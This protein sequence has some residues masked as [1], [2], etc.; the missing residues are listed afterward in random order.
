MLKKRC[1]RLF[2]LTHQYIKPCGRKSAIFG[3]SG[4]QRGP[5]STPTYTDMA[6][7]EEPL[8]R[9]KVP[10]TAELR[11][12]KIWGLRNTPHDHLSVGATLAPTQSEY[13]RRRGTSVVAASAAGL[14]TV[15]T[16]VP[17]LW[18]V[19]QLDLQMDAVILPGNWG[20]T[21]IRCGAYRDDD[22]ARHRSAHFHR[23]HL[24]EL[25]R[26]TQTSVPVSRLTC[27]YGFESRASALA[28]ATSDRLACYEVEPVDPN[29]PVSRH[30]MVWVTRMGEPGTG[31]DSVVSQLHAYWSGQPIRIFIP[32]ATSEWEWLIASG[33]R[34]TARVA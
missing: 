13:I 7:T 26:V 24:L 30:D 11:T 4:A 32:G 31:F 34:V 23:E 19:S 25:F 1:R 5:L 33:L 14:Q 16:Q 29:Q 2:W 18:H 27:A 17:R 12:P 9:G 6:A 22:D 3:F 10:H 8:A 21:T 28:R 15:T 20:Q